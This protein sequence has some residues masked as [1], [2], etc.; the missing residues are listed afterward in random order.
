MA[1]HPPRA[2]RFI[3]LGIRYVWSE[4]LAWRS[5]FDIIWGN[6]DGWY[7]GARDTEI[8]W[9]N[10]NGLPRDRNTP[11]YFISD[12]RAAVTDE[13]RRVLTT[14]SYESRMAIVTKHG[15]KYRYGI[16]RVWLSGVDW[17]RA[18]T[19]PNTADIRSVLAAWHDSEDALDAVLAQVRLM[20]TGRINRKKRP[21]SGDEPAETREKKKRRGH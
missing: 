14:G 16:T 12:L 11:I 8:L 1:L 2:R 18:S 20:R 5:D 19:V 21:P 6:D 9:C 15:F 7:R 4:S 3:D 10:S 17:Q 13:E